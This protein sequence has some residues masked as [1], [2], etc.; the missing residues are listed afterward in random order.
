MTNKAELKV[1]LI[2]KPSNLKQLVYTA[3]RTCYS[4][5]EPREIFEDCLTENWFDCSNCTEVKIDCA[6]CEQEKEKVENKI[7]K[8]IHKVVN[9]GHTSTLEHAYFVFAVSGISRVVLAQ[10][11]RHRH[12]SFSVKSQRYV[13][14]STPFK[15]IIPES[16]QKNKE[17]IEYLNK[18]YTVQELYEEHMA[19][20]Q[21]IYSKFLEAGIP[22]DDARFVFP[23]GCE[24]SM[25]TSCNLRELI[26]VCGLR[27]CSN[28]QKEI[29]QM[30]RKIVEEVVKQEP[31]L[32]KYLKSKCE[33]LGYCDEIHCCGK[34]QKKQNMTFI[35]EDC[36]GENV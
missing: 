9:S 36:N 11:T 16:I 30:Y 10:D 5:Q 13:K 4:D 6:T 3:M 19:N 18:K 12:K 22:A 33:L 1:K 2:S 29:Q 27:L 31:W 21:S 26:H 32:K 20:C 7:L 17:V 35:D 24:T 23:N 8:L 34:K 28:A 25:I 14:Y 15:Y